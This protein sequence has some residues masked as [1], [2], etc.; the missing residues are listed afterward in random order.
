[1]KKFLFNRA[2]RI[3]LITNGLILFSGAMLGPIYAIFVKEI[4]GDLLDASLT[5]SFFALAAGIT[6]LVAGKFADKKKRDELIVATGYSIMG[7][8]FLLYLFVN[9]IWFLFAVQILIGFAEAFYSPAFDSLYS[10]HITKR[11][12]GREWGAWEAVNYFSLGFGA[13]IGGIIANFLGFNIIFILMSSL[14]FISS[15]YIFHL[16]KKIL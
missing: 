11:K 16:H 2:L 9:S 6:T 5:G 14:C 1:M 13:I 12:A 15:A 8:G 7:F 10:K 4:G 3:L